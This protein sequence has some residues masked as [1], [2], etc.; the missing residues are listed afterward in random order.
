MWFYKWLL[1]KG[2]GWAVMNSGDVSTDNTRLTLALT[3]SEQNW[4]QMPTASVSCAVWRLVSQWA[5]AIW[6]LM[7][8]G[9]FGLVPQELGI[10]AQFSQ[11]FA[12]ITLEIETWAA[13]CSQVGW[14]QPA[15]SWARAGLPSQGFPLPV[16]QALHFHWGRGVRGWLVEGG[17]G[18]EWLHVQESG[19]IK[20]YK[21]TLGTPL[22][23]SQLELP[24]LSKGTLRSSYQ[25]CFLA[26]LWI[27]HR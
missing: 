19:N 24:G 16:R 15:P 1:Y 5:D 3:K 23:Q 12:N 4:F 21:L 6:E 10:P 7:G 20:L 11:C 17:W 18:I 27:S 2:R 25:R 9:R 14:A 8:C 22:I 13:H 26:Q